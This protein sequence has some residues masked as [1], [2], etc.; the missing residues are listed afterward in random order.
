MSV[1]IVSNFKSKVVAHWVLR[2]FDD[3]Y[4]RQ[5]NADRDAP[6]GDCGG[7]ASISIPIRV[8]SGNEI[9]PSLGLFQTHKKESL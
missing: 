5:Y 4:S 3:D 9:D 7:D 6:V 8:Q 1:F 2:Y